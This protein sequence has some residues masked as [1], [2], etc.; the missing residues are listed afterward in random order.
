MTSLY[1]YQHITI[2]SITINLKSHMDTIIVAQS[3]AHL[4]V[5]DKNQTQ[6]AI[7]TT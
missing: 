5:K 6:D 3:R 1:I 4:V 7:L 2:P